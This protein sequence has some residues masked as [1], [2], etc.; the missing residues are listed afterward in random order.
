MVGKA[1]S[2]RRQPWKKGKYR[3][4]SMA[5]GDLATD[6]FV[7][8]A[9]CSTAGCWNGARCAFG[10]WRTT[11]PPR[12]DLTACSR[13]LPCPP[14]NHPPWQQPDR[15][16]CGRHV[17]AIQD[18]SELE[19]SARQQRT[20]GLGKISNRK[21]A[22]VFLHPVLAIDAGRHDC[23]GIAHQQVRVRTQAAALDYDRLPI[24]EKES[25]RWLQAAQAAGQCLAQAA[26]VTV[27]ADRESDIYEEWDRLPDGQR[28][29]LTRVRCDRK[30]AGGDTL[31]ERLAAQPAVACY[32]LDVPARAAGRA[33]QSAD[34][35]RSGPRTA[36]R[37]QM[38][39]R[40]G[41]VRSPAPALPGAAAQRD[42]SQWPRCGNC[43]RPCRPGAGALAAFEHAWNRRRDARATPGGL[44]PA[45]L[46]DR[47]AV[48]HVEAAR[49]GAG[50][51]PVGRRRRPAEA[52]QCGRAGGRAHPA[53]D[54]CQG[55]S[56]TATRQRCL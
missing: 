10:S 33:Y 50:E 7:E 24:E 32:A 52:G 45:A 26:M 23:L 44:A 15:R 34:G 28:H 11:V 37:A 13:I 42:H 55:R 39:V 8:L 53:T 56:V 35:A 27:I 30:L 19:D 47:T 1:V 31:F 9:S 43:R 4:R 22:G 2:G 38:A 49:T 12:S 36:H 48:S 46:A 6:V 3:A 18:T 51:P 40:F 16:R 17:L 20:Q 41:R 25:Y 5:S 21:G 14:G 54:Q 29:L